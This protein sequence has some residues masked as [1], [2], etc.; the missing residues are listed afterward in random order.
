MITVL[1]KYSRV[2]IKQIE[3]KILGEAM[4]IAN[5]YKL[6]KRFSGFTDKPNMED[7][8][9]LRADIQL[10]E[11]YLKSYRFCSISRPSFDGWGEELNCRFTLVDIK[12]IIKI[13]ES[14]MK[15]P[16]LQVKRKNLIENPSMNMIFYHHVKNLLDD[17]KVV[18]IAM[19]SHRLHG[20]IYS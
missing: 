17:M 13:L 7:F 3:L 20:I 9:H 1:T 18:K 10:T 15:E 19:E 4:N 2:N 16:K 8:D 12:I 6:S 5:P 14:Y 11:S